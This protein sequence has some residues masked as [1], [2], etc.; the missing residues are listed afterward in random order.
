MRLGA[1]YFFD[2]SSEIPE[3][4]DV[5]RSLQTSGRARGAVA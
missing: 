1:E 4:L 5:L 2:K 3:M